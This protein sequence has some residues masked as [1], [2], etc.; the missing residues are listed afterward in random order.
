[1]TT[2]ARRSSLILPV[3][4]PR[5]VERAYTRG[6]D[7]IVLDLEDSVPADRKAEARAAVV[8]S[9]A[10]LQAH[11]PATGV[12]V[13]PNALDTDLYGKDLAAVV[14]PGVH[15]LLLPK[16]FGARDVQDVAALVALFEVENG[17]QNGRVELVPSLETARSL[18]ACEQVATAHRRV[19]ALMVAAARDADVSLEVG[20]TW[21]PEGTETLHYRSRA[22]LA[23]RAAGAVHPVC[24]LW[25]DVGDLA[26][27][28]RFATANRS[29]G[30]RGQVVIHPSH[31]AVVN[32]VYSPDEQVVER[33]REPRVRGDRIA[34]ASMLAP[35]AHSDAEPA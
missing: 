35:H 2:L 15:A 28:E 6:A 23:C 19:A 30:Y 4:I 17:V 31:V 14:R 26:G 33:Y 22:L 34:T 24:G 10:W 12:L 3:N 21:T 27:L 8:D 11:S 5:F 32:R 29:L 25:Q 7:A 1:M 9:V 16:V 18:V 20:F 13:R